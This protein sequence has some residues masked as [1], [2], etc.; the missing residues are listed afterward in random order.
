MYFRVICVTVLPADKI[1]VQTETRE[2]VKLKT[3]LTAL[4]LQALSGDNGGDSAAP[5]VTDPGDQGDPASVLDAIGE[6][7]SDRVAAT[8]KAEVCWSILCLSASIDSLGLFAAV[9]DLKTVAGFSISAV[10]SQLPKQL[11]RMY[12]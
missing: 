6:I 1:V 10:S 8:A 4:R 2:E 5:S 7:A 3:N 12:Q 9:H 11:Q